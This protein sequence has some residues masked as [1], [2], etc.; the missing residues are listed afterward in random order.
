MVVGHILYVKILQ[1]AILLYILGHIFYLYSI[2][3]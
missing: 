3:G 1:E 2:L